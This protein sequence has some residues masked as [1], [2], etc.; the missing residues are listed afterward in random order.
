MA[1]TKLSTDRVYG[2]IHLPSSAYFFKEK[3]GSHIYKDRYDETF[4]IV[5]ANGS[6]YIVEKWSGQCPC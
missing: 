2:K 4:W 6:G 1:A 5:Y 3:D